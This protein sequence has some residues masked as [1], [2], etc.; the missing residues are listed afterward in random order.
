M[1]AMQFDLSRQ[2]N[3][4]GIHFFFQ[5]HLMKKPIHVS[6]KKLPGVYSFCFFFQKSDYLKLMEL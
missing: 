4:D 5:K 6:I 2:F 1:I 3:S